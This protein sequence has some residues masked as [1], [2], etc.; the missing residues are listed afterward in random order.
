M[1]RKR[2]LLVILSLTLAAG[3]NPGI[4]VDAPELPDYKEVT[5]EGDGGSWECPFLREG[6]KRIYINYP[7]SDLEY[8]TYYGSGGITGPDCHPSELESIVF[9]NPAECYSIGFNGNM[10]YVTC[11]YSNRQDSILLNF[12]YD[13][14]VTKTVHITITQGRPLTALFAQYE[15]DLVLEEDFER[16]VRQYGFLNNGPIPQKVVVYPYSSAQCSSIVVPEAEWAEGMNL[17]MERPFFDGQDWLYEQ[18]DVVTGKMDNFIPSW[19]MDSGQFTVEVPAGVKA[20]VSI[21]PHY[22]RAG[23]KGAMHFRNTVAGFETSVNFTCTVIY[24]V[25][26]E[27]GV[28]YE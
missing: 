20:K 8:V 6:L 18:A 26:Y 2:F 21:M 17:T 3:C 25:S 14:G 27:Y 19:M 28:E 10:L 23:R 13:W 22:T 4:F 24:P 15:T 1:W 16:V 9:E 12:E 11:G 7:V 5:I